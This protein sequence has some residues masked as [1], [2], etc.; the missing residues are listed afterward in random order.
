M[1]FIIRCGEEMKKYSKLIATKINEKEIIQQ[2][3]R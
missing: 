1:K 3:C 2:N